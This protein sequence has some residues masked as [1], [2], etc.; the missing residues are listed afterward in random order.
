MAALAASYLGTV[1]L[2]A[3]SILLTSASATYTIPYGISVAASNRVGNAMGEAL[4]QKARKASM[5][6]LIFAVA[7]SLINSL[8]FLTTRSF[9]GYLFTS[10]ED[11]VARV[12]HILP[13]CALFQI[14]DGLCGVSG[15][16]IRG[17][18]RQ[19]VAAWINLIAYYVV[20]LPLGYPMTFHSGWGLMGIWIALSIALFVGAF[21]E[22]LFLFTI[23][24]DAE[25]RRTHERVKEEEHL[26]HEESD[27][28]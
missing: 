24:W 1:D 22:V 3:Q 19:K 8:F 5:M 13:L 7:F 6:A 25:V 16:V 14:A 28:A 9:Y 15:G 26:I 2:A 17:L 11:V 18:G 4:A 10:D 21:G 23:N 20:A 27:I 12:A